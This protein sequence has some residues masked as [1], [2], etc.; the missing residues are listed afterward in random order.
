MSGKTFRILPKLAALFCALLMTF[1]FAACGGGDG[2]DGNNEHAHSFASTLTQGDTEHYYECACGA[3]QGNEPHSYTDGVCKCGKK[4]PNAHSHEFSTTLTQGDTEHYYECACG[5]RQGSEPHSYTDGVCKCGKKDPASYS[6]PESVNFGNDVGVHD[7]SIFK[8]PKDGTYYAFGS[9]FAVASSTDL[10]HWTQRVGDGS[11]ET[12]GQREAQNLYGNGVNWR[13]VLTQAVAHAG[14]T[15]PSTWAPDVEY[16]NGKYYMYVSLSSFGTQKS[17]IV[18][19]EAD[20]VLGV[21]GNERMIVKSSAGD[22]PNCIDPEL[23]YDKEGGLWMVYGSFFGG[24]YI[25]ELYNSGANWGLPKEDGFGTLLWKGGGTG[26]EGPYIFRNGD[27][28]Y[29]MV[30]DGSLSTNYNMRVAR[31]TSP[32]GPY[33]DITG[34]DMAAAY[35]K[36]NKLAGNWQFGGETGKA[37]YGHNS[38]CEID[39][40]YFTVAH[41]R[42]Q[43][44]NGGV[45]GWHNLRVHR[46]LF[47][48]QGWPVLASERYAGETL[49]KIAKSEIAG[50]YDLILHSEGM[51]Q[52]FVSSERYTFTSDGKITG[53][54]NGVWNFQ[55]DGNYIEITLNGVTY[56]GVAMP[57]WTSDGG[58]LSLSAVSDAGRSLWANAVPRAADPNLDIVRQVTGA[59]NNISVAAFDADEGFTVSFRAAVTGTEVGADWNAHA[60]V[61]RGLEISLPNLRATE[62]NEAGVAAGDMY[63]G[64]LGQ[65]VGNGTWNCYL[66]KTCYV[67]ITL[68]RTDGIRFYQD[69][70][71]TQSYP[72]VAGGK[73]EAFVNAFLN[74]VKEDGFVFAES[75][76][77][78]SDLIVSRGAANAVSAK[79]IY[80]YYG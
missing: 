14:S 55:A 29:L 20:S 21:Y 69:G 68:S 43:D 30:S 33:Y 34:A 24:I 61:C 41:M 57:V 39:G 75:G 77:T 74:G 38:V 72:A 78:A 27:Y 9:H 17:A 15:S 62:G 32:A 67:T 18:R 49:G 79:A 58:K 73:A 28:Y 59:A 51:P 31:S 7:P 2:S 22:A 12:S 44:E 71:C 3:R 50:K 80:E 52:T 64:N 46:L 36:G 53:A 6:F 42:Y 63:P 54:A 76:F 11:D 70:A 1:S 40:E 66:G 37:A 35:G 25:K 47:N 26:P 56:K 45:T 10:I 5:A 23:F 19:V 48:E 16:Y 4:D 8:D 60:L 65:N 13:T